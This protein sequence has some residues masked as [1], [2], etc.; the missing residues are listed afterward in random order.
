MSLKLINQLL[1]TWSAQQEL[2]D[3]FSADMA[4]YEYIEQILQYIQLARFDFDE[5]ENVMPFFL[6]FTTDSNLIT[7]AEKMFVGLCAAFRIRPD[8]YLCYLTGRTD[9]D[10]DDARR[11]AIRYISK[12]DDLF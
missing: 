7:H 4:N 10:V 9:A 12:I 1:R 2:S 8:Q 11:C 5:L 6:K 3:K